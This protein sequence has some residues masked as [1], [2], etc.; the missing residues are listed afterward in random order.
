MKILAG[1]EP[2][3]IRLINVSLANVD[4]VAV[5]FSG[6]MD[7]TLLLYMLIRE[8]ESLGL[9]TEIHCFT[10]TQCG[11]KIHSQNVLALPE[12]AGK[13]IHHT[14]VD[15]PI[16]ESVKPVIRN[17]LDAGWITYGASNTVPLEEIGGRYPPR[18]VKN[19]DNP[20]LIL[21][22]LFLFKYHILDAYYK[23]EIQHILPT[24]HTCTEI[25]TGECG[26]C[27]A[28]REKDWAYTKLNIEKGSL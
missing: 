11:T 21:P 1:L 10:A 26:L 19:P 24:T 20:N 18:P 25:V 14:D 27:Y 9:N 12:F 7:S 5:T 13:V 6:G 17:L 28:C 23:L 15:N 8:K 3:D 2:N 4:K 22:F 16:N